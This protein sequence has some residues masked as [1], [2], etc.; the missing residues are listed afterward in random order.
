MYWPK[1]YGMSGVSETY[2]I[3]IVRISI[4]CLISSTRADDCGE[5][6]D[7]ENSNLIVYP[8]IYSDTA[9]SS[10]ETKHVDLRMPHNN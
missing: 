9:S 2:F 3:V 6:L 8:G 1:T 10:S 5:L 7:F 4:G